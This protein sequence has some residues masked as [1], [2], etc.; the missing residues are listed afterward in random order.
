MKHLV[1]THR[2]EPFIQPKLFAPGPT[3]V[4]LATRL[5]ALDADVYHR[6]D[7]FY[8]LHKRCCEGLQPIFGSKS[9]PVILASSGSGAMEAAMTN[10]TREG[11]E[12]VT[13]VAGKFGER[14]RDLARTWKCSTTVVDIPWGKAVTPDQVVQALSGLKNPRA[15]F[16]QANETSTGV[17]F[18]VEAIAA[19]VRRKF[20]GVF[21]VVDAISSLCAHPLHMESME[22]DCVVAGSQKGFGMA[23]G[24]A[25]IS[26]SERAWAGLSDRPRFYFDLARERKGQEKGRSAWTPAISLIQSLAVAL[27]EI[28]S[29]GIDN[30]VAH[31]AHMGRAT[32]AAVKAMGLE[33][34]AHAP[35]DAL[36]AISVPPGIDGSKL[37]EHLRDRY[38][39]IFSGG[40][41]QL[42][43]RIIRFAH[44]GF[45][46][47]FDVLHGLAA[48]EF[49][50][51]DM[52]YPFAL[53][54]GVQAA[55]REMQ[56][57][58]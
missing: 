54:T 37:V 9:F 41:D 49:A 1:Q 33:L 24:L 23:P 35:S 34:F 12:V 11:D 6:A 14:W 51:A 8:A 50:L 55:M 43:G 42:K 30:M 53:G 29:L 52:G 21:I 44:L 16:V 19:E 5:A 45:A 28:N 57:P 4:P 32:R 20:P 2:G 27:N 56:K 7:D 31:H 13:V 48:L 36:T 39:A 25:F 18:P 58:V 10:L 38:G 17:R 47:R 22:L 46:S 3:P 15:V 26:L 40:Q